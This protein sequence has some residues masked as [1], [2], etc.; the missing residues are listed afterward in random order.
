ML[1]KIH[2]RVQSGPFHLL[3]IIIKPVQ[4]ECILLAPVFSLKRKVSG[5]RLWD[6][7]HSFSHFCFSWKRALQFRIRT[8]FHW[9]KSVRSVAGHLEPCLKL[10]S[11]RKKS[12]RPRRAAFSKSLVQLWWVVVSPKTDTGMQWGHWALAVMKHQGQPPSQ[13]AHPLR[14]YWDDNLWQLVFSLPLFPCQFCF[15]FGVGLMHCSWPK[16]WINVWMRRRVSLWFSE[17]LWSELFFR[18]CVGTLLAWSELSVADVVKQVQQPEKTVR[19]YFNRTQPFGETEN[20]PEGH[21]V[22]SWRLLVKV[23]A[24]QKATERQFAFLCFWLVPSRPSFCRHSF[25]PTA[26][27][28]SLTKSKIRKGIVHKIRLCQYK[29]Q[30]EKATQI[31]NEVSALLFQRRSNPITAVPKS[32]EF[33]ISRKARGLPVGDV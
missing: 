22:F 14:Y 5:L 32:E 1:I 29:L 9:W 13:S 18:G 4:A 8:N 17:T 21:T 31:G 2:C 27:G 19:F 24:P 26:L 20:H 12:H 11:V 28:E 23:S 25:T 15:Q 7:M 30:E 33:R 16:S 10:V 3:G 6:W